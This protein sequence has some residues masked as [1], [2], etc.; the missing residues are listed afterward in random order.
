MIGCA[1]MAC[2]PSASATVTATT[3]TTP[4]SGSWLLDD[5]IT[6]NEAITV[7]GTTVGGTSA[8]AVDINCY[9]GA[10]SIVRLATGVPLAQDGSFMVTLAQGLRQLAKETCVLRAV[11]AGDMAPYPPGSGSPYSGPTLSIDQLLDTTGGSAQ[12]EYYYLYASQLTGAFDFRSLGNC[13]VNNSYVYDPVTFV[14]VP[15][16]A[17]NGGFSSVNSN[18]APTRSELVVDGADAYLAGNAFDIAGFH[19][20]GNPGYPALTYSYS[21]DPANGDLVLDEIDQVVK[22]SPGGSYPPPGA[23]CSRFLPTGVAVRLHITQAQGGRMANVVQYF[24]STDGRAHALDLLEGNQFRA[25]AHDGEL[26]LPWTG[27]GL[28]MYAQRGQ[29]VAGP[30]TIGPGSFFVKGSASVPDGSESSAQGSVSFS[31]PPSSVTVVEPTT[32]GASWLELGYAR[33]VPAS[34]SVALGFTYSDAFYASEAFVYAVAAE[35]AFRP[36]VAI[37][38]PVGR[39]E[40]SRPRVTVSGRA[41]DHSGLSIVTVDGRLVAVKPDGTW[42]A[43]VSLRPGQN[44][45][46]AAASNV[47]GNVTQTRTSVIYDAAR[48]RVRAVSETN[49]VWRESGPRGRRMPPIGTTFKFSLSEAV[50]VALAFTEQVPGRRIAHRCVAPGRG[51]RHGPRCV[52]TGIVATTSIPGRR[53][54]NRFQFAGVVDGRALAPGRYTLVIVADDGGVLSSPRRLSFTIVP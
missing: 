51:A 47:F 53:G 48:P 34:G 25:P 3:I 18:T 41:T 9:S 43:T 49:T 2:P 33:T 39:I 12:L 37:T 13:P 16:D 8:D 22:C 50:P 15:L 21:I 54:R 30:R 1:V 32:N 5:Q 20:A 40:T 31:N 19:G 29:V 35:A 27:T 4:A 45:I 36:L 23:S 52:R 10:S 38:S 14:R 42:T 28:Q 26:D 17:C 44:T 7:A 46:T 11:P 24:S 6:P